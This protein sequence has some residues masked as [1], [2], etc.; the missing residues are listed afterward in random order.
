MLT[1]LFTAL[2]LV[3]A[4]FR[5]AGVT[6]EIFQ[7]MAHC[8]VGGVF[9]AGWALLEWG[10]D[11]ETVQTGRDWLFIAGAI[12]AVEVVCFAVFKYIL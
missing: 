9:G 8:F 2:A 1:R 6:G 11:D 4:S 3:L 12:T 10:K 5:V 7:A